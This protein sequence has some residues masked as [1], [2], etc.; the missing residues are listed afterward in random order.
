MAD[1]E[2]PD[3]LELT[4]HDDSLKYMPGEVVHTHNADYRIEQIT[5]KPGT[6]TPHKMFLLRADLVV[7]PIVQYEDDKIKVRVRS[8]GQTRNG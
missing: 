7:K 1:E 6:D 8:E 2:S 5:H 3:T 4:L